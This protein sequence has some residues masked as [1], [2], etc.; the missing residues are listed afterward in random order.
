MKSLKKA[1]LFILMNVCLFLLLGFGS[2]H[3][4]ASNQQIIMGNSTGKAGETVEIPI[5]LKSE[6]NVSAIQLQISYDVDMLDLIKV[7][8]GSDLQSSFSVLAHLENG[9]MVIGSLGSIIGSGTKEVAVAV[10]KIKANT[11]SNRYEIELAEASFSDSEAINL[12]SQFQVVDGAITVDNSGFVHVTGITVNPTSLNLTAEGATGAITATIIPGNASIKDVTWGSSDE[13]V[14]VVVDGAVTP[15][16]AGTA[17]I[18]ATTEDGNFTATSVVTMQAD[19]STGGGGGN[20]P[21]PIPPDTTTIDGN[22]IVNGKVENAGTAT[23][24]T[25]NNQQVTTITV[26]PRKLETL[27]AA[28]ADGTLI[29]ISVNTQSDVVVSDLMDKWSKTWSRSRRSWKSKQ[30]MPSTPC[31][32]SRS[33]SAPYP[34]RLAK[35]WSFKT[36]I[37]RL[38]SPHRQLTW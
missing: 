25:V 16:A 26:D 36:S 8:K 34:S 33:I 20:N 15:V 6:G 2:A 10:F 31:L 9:K 18:M 22:I 13:D 1:L 38:N 5:I 24:T 12:S 28:E 32:L 17:T 14:A 21:T 3:A 30:I 23:M 29:T 35:I 11:A 7:N 37:L 4:A 27:L 19:I